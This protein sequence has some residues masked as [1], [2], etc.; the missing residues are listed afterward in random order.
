MGISEAVFV[1]VIGAI[2]GLIGSLGG[3]F[4]GNRIEQR[5]MEAEEDRWYLARALE[6]KFTVLEGLYVQALEL[7]DLAERTIVETD[8]QEILTKLRLLNEKDASYRSALRAASVYLDEDGARLIQLSAQVIGIVAGTAPQ[9]GQMTS[10]ELSANK[11]ELL[12]RTSA[13]KDA[14]PYLRDLLNPKKLR[15]M[16]KRK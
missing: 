4:L 11:Q 10:E 13:L 16:A 15:E 5:K 1:A 2:G 12:A 9:K 7:M 8:D 6:R 3:V 14:L